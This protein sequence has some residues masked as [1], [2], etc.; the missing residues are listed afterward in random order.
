MG[1]RAQADGWMLKSYRRD[2]RLLESTL[3][4]ILFRVMLGLDEPFEARID[5]DVVRAKL[6]PASEEGV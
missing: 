3:S 1:E 2:R 4:H 5:L 6:Q